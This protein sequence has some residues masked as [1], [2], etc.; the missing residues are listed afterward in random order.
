MPDAL[1]GLSP[2][3]CLDLGRTVWGIDPSSK[4]V[5]LAVLEP[6]SPPA[7]SWGV[8]SLGQPDHRAWKFNVGHGEQ[9]EFFG[10]W[11]DR[12]YPDVVYLEEP[13]LPR[14]RREAP[15]HLLMYGVTL[16]ALGFALGS[17]VP[18]REIGASSWKARAMGQGYGHAKKPEIMRWAHAA[19][20]TGSIEDEADA[21]GIATAG[22]VLEAA[23]Q[24]L[25]A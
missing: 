20:Y 12:A 22:A 21:V 8:V 2:P 3:A 13:F 18:V 6:G 23:R 16:A 17:T 5:A 11:A 1:P 19:G 14:D 4:R 7:L 15:T 9:L 10:E 25:A 24:E